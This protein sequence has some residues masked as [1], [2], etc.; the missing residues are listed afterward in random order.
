ME[1]I[2]ELSDA[3]ECAFSV[4]ALSAVGLE[5]RSYREATRHPD[6]DKWHKCVVQEM[7]AHL[8]NGTWELV[9]LPA[10]KRAIGSRWVFKIKRKPDGSIERYKGRLVAQGFSQRPGV[11]FGETF[12]PTTKWAALHA[13]LTL[14]AIEDLEL[15][16]VDISTAYLNGILDAEVYMKQPEGFQRGGPEW[17]ARLLKGLYG[18]KQGG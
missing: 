6:A 2:I 7:Q 18:L 16:S 8:E 17:V 3:M 15:W 9:K 5:P 11:E 10:G 4:V 14:A 12:A 13:I 1:D